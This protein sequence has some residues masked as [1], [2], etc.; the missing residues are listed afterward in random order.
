MAL[1]GLLSNLC[2]VEQDQNSIKNEWLEKSRIFQ[3]DIL[4]KVN[5]M[6]KQFREI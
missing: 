1:Y 2:M 4:K 6:T 5:G 3:I